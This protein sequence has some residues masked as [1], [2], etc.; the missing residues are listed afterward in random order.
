[1]A[2]IEAGG[3]SKENLQ[4]SLS[5][6]G[7]KSAAS[8][9]KETVRCSSRLIIKDSKGNVLLDKTI[10]GER[11]G[12]LDRESGSCSASGNYSLTV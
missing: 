12:V 1:M 8:D 4:I 7:Y 2:L 6:T 3:S 10:N 9:W 11:G 5:A